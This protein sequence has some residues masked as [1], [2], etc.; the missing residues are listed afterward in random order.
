MPVFLKCGWL[1]LLVVALCGSA[2]ASDAVVELY[3]HGNAQ[4]R[5]GDY[6]RAI[7]A[8]E[9]V[10]GQGFQNGDVYY[11]LANAYYKTDQLGP[12][13]LF[14]ERAL[15][16]MPGDED[17]LANLRFANARRV[18]KDIEPHANFL[19]RLLRGVY[20]FWDIN[21]LA[22][23]CLVFVFGIGGTLVAWLF[24]P[25]RRLIYVVLLVIFGS[26][27]AASGVLLAFKSHDGSVVAAIVIESEVVGRSGPGNDFLQVFV[28]HEGTKVFVERVEGQWILVTLP[29]G[30]GGW[31]QRDMLEQI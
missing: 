27:L 13:I 16:L 6:E 31:V 11:N 30:V 21:T 14:Y 17:V 15:K 19:T 26:G 23:F 25:L 28:L 9:R 29:N 7:K 3:N 1:M 2:N 24:V 10:I 5:Q 22:V 18:D 20:D 12:A 4:Y 8:Y